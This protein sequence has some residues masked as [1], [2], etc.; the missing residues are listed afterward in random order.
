MPAAYV[1]PDDLGRPW[2]LAIAAG[3]VAGAVAAFAYAAISYA[4]EREVLIAIIAIGMVVGFVVRSVSGRPG[5]IGG[6]IS[7]VIAAAATL[8]AVILLVVFTAAD[9]IP[10]GMKW[11]GDVDYAFALEVYFSDFLS[12]VFV[13][14]S[15][16]FAF[17]GGRKAKDKAQHVATPAAD[18]A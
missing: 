4:I 13:A 3:L 10:D 17:L 5:W 18:P 1:S 11:L 9:S 12:Y 15:L 6:M 16:L 7:L 14:A 8:A 2:I